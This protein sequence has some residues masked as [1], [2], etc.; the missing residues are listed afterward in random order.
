VTQ[1]PVARGTALVWAWGFA[2]LALFAGLAVF[3]APLEPGVVALQLTFT[4]RAFAA[5]VHA[6]PPEDL[7][8]Y[9]AHLPVDVALLLA[10]GTFGRLLA[11]RTR[12][13]ARAGTRVH[14]ALAWAM[15]L[16]AAFD[17]CEDA[18][19]A[20]LTEAPRFDVP[21]AYALAGGCAAAKWTLLVAFALAA[22]L[23]LARRLSCD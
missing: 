1:G 20:W 19:H 13:F 15:P 8:R 3:L 7:A 14:A 17:A 22:L 10:Y 2:A 4:P 16:A 18:L 11:T 5:I 12:V 23:A 6:W 21:Q 9:R